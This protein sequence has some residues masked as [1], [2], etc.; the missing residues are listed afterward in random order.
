MLLLNGQLVSFNAAIT[1]HF[2]VITD[3]SANQ[4]AYIN[5]SFLYCEIA[6]IDEF[7]NL[8]F[9]LKNNIFTNKINYFASEYYQL[10][11]DRPKEV[12]LENISD[13]IVEKYQPQDDELTFAEGKIKYALHSKKERNKKVVAL[14]KKLAFDN[15]P[16]LPCEIC[17]ISF[18]D[19]YGEIGEGFIEAHHIFPISELTEETET[20]LEDLIL[21]CCNCHKI[22]HHKRPWLTIENIK[23][24]LKN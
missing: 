19:K 15:N 4:N 2:A 11:K 21:V 8:I 24:L 7:K 17:G 16:L 12:T 18:K 13:E 3:S 10:T 6:E 23:S 14:K 20:R 1:N 9:R 5:L 22:I